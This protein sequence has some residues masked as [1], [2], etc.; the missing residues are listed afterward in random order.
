MSIL[1]KKDW[2][3]AQGRP[4]AVVQRNTK[5]F[6]FVRMVAILAEMGIK[7]NLFHLSLYDPKLLN[8]DPHALNAETDPTG[9]LRLRVAYECKRNVWYYLREVVRIPASG[10][11][12]IHFQ[13]NRGNLSMAWCFLNSIDY[14]GTQPRQSGKFQKL[15]SLVKVPGG[16]KRM[17]EIQL[18]DMVTAA[19]GT[20]S[21]VIGIYPQGMQ[22]SYKITFEDG[23]TT[24][25]G[26]DH[27]WKVY[28]AHWSPVE[29]RWRVVPFSVIKERLDRVPDSSVR[30]QVPLAESEKIGEK[31]LP[32]DPYVLGVLLG[33]GGVS[34]NTITI[35]TDDQFVLDEV[36]RIMPSLEITHSER[37]SY[38]VKDSI[39][40]HCDRTSRKRRKLLVDLEKLEVMGCNA[41]NKMIPHDYLHGSTEQRR[42]LV[43]GLIDT[44]GYVED[45]G[46]IEYCTTSPVL[47]QQFQYLVR[48]L[49]GLCKMK[50]KIP[51][52]S[53]KG[54]KRTGRLAYILRPRIV[55][56]RQLLRLPRKRDKLPENYKNDDRL[57]LAITGYEYMGKEESQCIEIAHP[58]HLY[59]TDDFIVTH[60]TIGAI[61]LSSWIMYINGYNMSMSMLTHSDKLVQENV[62]RLK[63]IKS[64]LP[65]Y[66]IQKSGDDIDNKQGLD[67]KVLKNSYI[68]YI[69]QK[70]KQAANR[71]GR[72]STSP[73]IHF[74]ELAFI[75]NIRITF[76][77]IMAATNTAR[78]NAAN[79]G[80]IHS[81]IYTTTAGDPSTDEGAF[82]HDRIKQS[83]PFTEKLYD[84]ED[85]EKAL[86]IVGKNS[87]IKMVNGTFSYL[88]L[89]FTKEWFLDTIT[90]NSVPPDEVQR[91][92]LN[93]WVCMAK[94]PIIPKETL[95]VMSAHRRPDPEYQ[96]I[97]GD[98]VISW[99]VPESTV[100][101]P[102]FKKKLL[103]LG[104]DSSE[105]IGRDFTTFVCIDP[106]T[107]ATVFTFRCNDSNT[108]KIG[109]LVARILNEYPRMLF[110][111]ERKNS[112]VFIVDMVITSMRRVGENP[113]V[114]IFNR[115]VQNRQYDEFSRIDL[116]DPNLCDSTDRKYLGF[117]TT[118]TSR[119]ILYKQVLQRAAALA[120]EKVYD[121]VLISELSG[122]Q[123]VNGRIDHR[124]GKTDDM[125]IAWTLACFV[126]FEGS[127]LELYGIHKDEL[128]KTLDYGYSG[129]VDQAKLDE[130]M[131]IRK[132]LKDL[133][134]RI[135]ATSSPSVKSF[136]T[137]ERSRLEQFVDPSIILEPVSVDAVKK[138]FRDYEVYTSNASKLDRMNVNKNDLRNVALGGT[139]YGRAQ[140]APFQVR[141]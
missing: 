48:S 129:N 35:T 81:N 2:L 139:P 92:Y 113:F 32:V 87:T 88:Q 105:N 30:M 60:N 15:D 71:V 24:E 107:L 80:M 67:Y 49:G 74:D 26:L 11:D 134:R 78:R 111:P 86:E 136:L 76:P 82:A 65:S 29:T 135:A 8:V 1:F 44:D 125:V 102:H 121:P 54:E 133:N 38:R 127:N 19:D 63:D 4:R 5:N 91:D 89:G 114:R 98:F 31:D 21:P 6:S 55:S 112:G 122:L 97:L 131:S 42:S 34:T 39:Y 138:D 14:N 100:R 93:N 56:P 70:D 52:Y 130:Q 58:S 101:S 141:Y 62:K 72:G 18:G 17:G 132:A 27:L 37:Y 84:S 119:D 23:R 79:A 95:D 64:T 126:I 53:W 9:D 40:V 90:R 69:G 108:T 3:D 43:Q 51:T 61:T 45:G 103:I 117:M 99:Y 96:E 36:R 115:V 124:A 73:C 68:T 41:W 47:A 28:N 110:V 50:T 106:A 75:P 83:M 13:L 66:L 12:P 118:G 85:R 57:R 7:N 137:Q 46:S 16:W 109:M 77:A 25:C 116:N 120:K 140:A 59:V 22:D 123:A 20:P 94:N 10:G 128:I 104:M 33:D